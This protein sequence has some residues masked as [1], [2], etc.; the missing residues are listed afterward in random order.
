MRVR[1]L[2]ANLDVNY[3]SV[4]NWVRGQRLPSEENCIK[5]ANYFQMDPARILELAGYGAERPTE[6]AKP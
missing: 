5:M 3:S 1:Q 2:A 4:G 6:G